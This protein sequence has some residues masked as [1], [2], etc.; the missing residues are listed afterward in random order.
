MNCR[1][2]TSYPVR[3]AGDAAVSSDFTLGLCVSGEYCA[4]TQIMPHDGRDT[5]VC[6]QVRMLKICVCVCVMVGVVVNDAESKCA[7]GTK[8]HHTLGNSSV[9]V[10]V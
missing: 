8:T 2:H 10:C 1:S 5:C 4:K 7:L 6:V 9:S 3:W